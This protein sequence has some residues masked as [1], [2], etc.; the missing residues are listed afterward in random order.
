VVSR[1]DGKGNIAT[2]EYNTGNKVSKRIDQG[3]ITVTVDGKTTTYNY[4]DNGARQNVIYS[5]GAREDYTYYKDGLLWTLTNKKSD[6]TIIDSYAYAY[7]AAHD[8]KSRMQKEPLLTP[9][10][11]YV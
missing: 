11:T 9:K 5:G 7:D 10:C 8:S 6:G 3:G 4:L 2:Y 1:T